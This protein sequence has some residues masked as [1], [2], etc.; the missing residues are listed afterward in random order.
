MLKRIPVEQVRLGM[1]LHSLCGSWLDHPFWATSFVIEDMATLD[2]LHNSPIREVVIDTSRGRDVDAAPLAGSADEERLKAELRQAG[3]FP[4]ASSQPSIEQVSLDEELQRAAR[5]LSQAKREVS[6]LF[7]QARLGRVVQA[8][9]FKPLAQ[10][11]A[12]SVLR[13]P[14]ALIS[15][16][17]L[18]AK[19]DYTYL[20]SVAVGALMTSLAHQLGLSPAETEHAALAGL[21]HDLGKAAIPLEILNKPGRLTEAEFDQVKAHP[22]AGRDMLVRAGVQSDMVLDVCLHHHEKIDGSGYPDGLSGQAI[23]LYAKMGAVCD[24]Y[25]AITSDRPYKA[26]W[27]PAESLKKMALW[28]KQGHFDERIFQAFVKCVGIYPTGSLVRLQSGRLGVVLD[29]SERSLL[30]PRVKVFFS[31]KSNT[32][33]VPEVLEL[34]TAQTND[35]IV[36]HE[37][38]QAWGIANLDEL[39]TGIPGRRP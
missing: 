14:A 27:H 4:H 9:H 35:R 36:G 20:H 29:Q 1:Y 19:D 38:P 2:K 28:A 5:I 13:N 17:R 12:N 39:W 26:G 16:A 3:D 23:S 30:L 31:T 22:R 10:E 24:V 7:K 21:L 15:L 32:Y 18:K 6:V 34:G 37:D 11:V 25:D 33:I 8:D